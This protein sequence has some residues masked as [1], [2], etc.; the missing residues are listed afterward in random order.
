MNLKDKNKLV[1]SRVNAV[2]A[3]KLKPNAAR[4]IKAEFARIKS[5]H[6]EKMKKLDEDTRPKKP[7]PKPRLTGKYKKPQATVDPF[8]DT[9]PVRR[10]KKK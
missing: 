8:P 5:K 6:A 9:V 3:S 4:L 1:E 2:M 7:P 10:R